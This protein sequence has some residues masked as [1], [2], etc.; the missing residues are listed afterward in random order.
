[1]HREVDYMYRS[2]M[3][4]NT[5]M[6]ARTEDTEARCVRFLHFIRDPELDLSS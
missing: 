6:K 2:K 5:I 3:R 4:E 1:M